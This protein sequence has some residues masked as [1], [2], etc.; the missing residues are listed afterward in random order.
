MAISAASAIGGAAVGKLVDL[1]NQNSESTQPME[2]NEG[3]ITRS[4]AAKSSSNSM[5]EEKA[6]QKRKNDERIDKIAR[7]SQ[8]IQEPTQDECRIVF[9]VVLS[10]DFH[11]DQSSDKLVILMGNPIGNFI[12]P[13]VEM[14]FQTELKNKYLFFKGWWNAPLKFQDVNIPY[15]YVVYKFDHVIEWEVL[16]NRYHYWNAGGP[17]N[18]CLKIRKGNRYD[19][20]ILKNLNKMTEAR[21]LSYKTMLVGNFHNF[22]S[23]SEKMDLFKLTEETL[24][25]KNAFSGEKKVQRLVDND[26]SRPFVRHC[27]MYRYVSK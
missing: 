15:K 4:R 7:F 27:N 19:D 12:D 14:K 6:R 22:W 23:P 2:T 17:V 11:F 5:N 25:I 20:A 24:K 16:P 1:F 8:E 3:P 10:P 13:Q 9:H 21:N 18:R 26:T